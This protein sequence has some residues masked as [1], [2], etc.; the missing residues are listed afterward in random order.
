[1]TLFAVVC[2]PLLTSVR[3]LCIF[4]V[5]NTRYK[6]VW[7]RFLTGKQLVLFDEKRVHYSKSIFYKTAECLAIVPL[8]LKVIKITLEFRPNL[9]LVLLN[10]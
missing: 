8:S 4:T 9:N 2:N 7:R 5:L 10:L 1:M 6:T 3:S